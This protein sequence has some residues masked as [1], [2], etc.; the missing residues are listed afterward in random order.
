[1]H[2]QLARA[3]FVALCV[4]TA[5][6]R[7]SSDSPRTESPLAP[8]AANLA[9]QGSCQTI[10]GNSGVLSLK[11]DL[12]GFDSYCLRIAG[13]SGELNCL[14]HDIQSL[15]LSDVHGMT[16]HNC[17]MRGLMSSRSSDITVVDNVFTADTRKTV[18][19]VLHFKDGT[20]NRVVANT[21]DG[22]WGLQPF[23]PG[24][25]P[26]GADDGILIEN[27]ANL[28]IEGNTIHN[29]WDCGVERLG[30]RTD[31]VTI[32]GNT[33]TFAGECGIGGW[34]AAGWSDA[35]IIDNTVEASGSFAS[36]YYSPN[37]NR[38]VDH[39]T[40]RNNVFEG[41]RFRNP[42]RPG[43]AS[44]RI[45]YVTGT[46][47]LPVDIGNNIFRNNDFGGNILAPQLAPAFGFVDGGDNI[48]R[49][50]GK[51]ALRCVR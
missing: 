27:D 18:A 32:R 51:S 36:I 49:E 42:W 37:Q 34:F 9:V 11:H 33:I 5:C 12:S 43:A 47:R 45:D 20:N 2:Q 4:S 6:S 8:S 44:V 7:G 41:N 25:F 15:E 38:G 50:D 24:G 28:L 48:C 39:I 10:T 35:L 19:T 1:M 22:S 3:V 46:S 23:P 30:N 16:V 13:G 21:I 14:G 40:F 17:R 26:P 31:P 29:V